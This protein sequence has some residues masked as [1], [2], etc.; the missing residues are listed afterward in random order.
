MSASAPV[1][2]TEETQESENSFRA[3]LKLSNF[4]LIWLGE[5]ISMLGDQ[6]YMIALPWLVLRL[7]GDAFAM[8]T[9]LAMAGI[10]RAAFMLLGGAITDRFSP[11]LVMFYSNIARMILVTGLTGLLLFGVV[12]LWMLYLFA[13]SFGLADAFFFPAQSSIVPQVAPKKHLQSA[14]S[15]IQGTGQLSLFAGPA[16][17]GILIA[18]FDNGASGDTTPLALQGLALALAVDAFTFLVSAIL[19]WMVKVNPTGEGKEKDAKDSNVLSS[20]WRGLVYVW[21]D[22]SLRGFFALIAA[23]NVLITSP[24]TVGIPVLADTRFSEGAAAFGILMSAL[25]GGSLI[26]II[27]A[28][29]LPKPPAKIMGAVIGIIWSIM[30]IAT[31]ILGF[32]DSTPLAALIMFI[33]G[34]SNGYVSILFITW[35]QERT[36]DMMLGRVM[37]LFMF[38]LFGLQ[39]IGNALAGAILS[40]NVTG[41]F[42]GS[43][44]LMTIII[45]LAMLH[46]ALRRMDTVSN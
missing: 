1:V 20:I 10:P 15:I 25:G 34:L 43:G 40:I 9:V 14:N 30:G 5:G 3:V 11:R 32:I 23:A 21:D 29:T 26:G 45:L 22:V 4:R 17:A 36:P 27:L 19:L 37:S 41:L 7:T 44:A 28:G 42:V 12:Q 38:A 16:L 31:I 2:S 35:L 46:P 39:P 6:F 18:L 8:G 24:M 33:S 13:L